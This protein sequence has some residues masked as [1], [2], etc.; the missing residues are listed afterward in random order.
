MATDLFGEGSAVIGKTITINNKTFHV[1]GVTKPKGSSGFSSPDTGVFIP[2]ETG[3][4]LVFGRDYLSIL[5]VQ[6][7]D[8]NL[9]GQTEADITQLILDNHKITDPTKADFHLATSKDAIS[10]LS[11]VTGL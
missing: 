5:F 4:K 6:T 10:A 9:N 7:V 2:L 3:S 11:T 8:A 1:V